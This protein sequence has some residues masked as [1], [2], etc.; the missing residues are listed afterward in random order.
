MGKDALTQIR[1]MNPGLY[2]PSGAELAKEFQTKKRGK[3]KS[4]RTVR[5]KIARPTSGYAA[6]LESILLWA[7]GER[8]DFPLVDRSGPLYCWRTE[9]RKRLNAAKK[10]HCA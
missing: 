8:G 2:I 10:R 3:S 5:R 1:K 7:L 9:M 4:A 6:T